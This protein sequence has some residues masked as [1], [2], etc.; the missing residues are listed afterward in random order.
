[1]TVTTTT[2]TREYTV[3]A[4]VLAIFDN[5]SN[6]LA[7]QGSGS[8]R[9]GSS[10]GPERREQKIRDAVQRILRDFPPGA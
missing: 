2:S 4:L 8:Q 10:G 1:M 9:I 3:G 7:W 5:D 6:D